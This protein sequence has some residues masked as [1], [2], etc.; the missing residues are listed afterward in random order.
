MVSA[1]E[2]EIL[3]KIVEASR[4]QGLKDEK[5]KVTMSPKGQLRVMEFEAGEG[6]PTFALRSD[7]KYGIKRI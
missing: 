3:K 6:G 5:F 2:K 1:F 7:I 4:G